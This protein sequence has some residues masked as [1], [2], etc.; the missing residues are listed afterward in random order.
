MAPGDNGRLDLDQLE[1]LTIMDLAAVGY[2]AGGEAA[3]DL[4]YLDDFA[5]LPKTVRQAPYRVG[6]GIGLGEFAVSGVGWSA[7]GGAVFDIVACDAGHP[8][9]A[10]LDGRGKPGFSGLQV[11]PRS[12]GIR[13]AWTSLRFDARADKRMAM[14]VFLDEDTGG[15]YTAIVQPNVTTEWQTFTV[16][17]TS[18]R[19][20][21]NKP[22]T[23]NGVLDTDRVNSVLLADVATTRGQAG[24]ANAFEIARPIVVPAPQ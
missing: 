15:A 10:R 18:F 1:Y 23:D 8:W 24:W 6:D 22:D 7:L 3:V 5:L 9:V 2:A 21:P 14:V 4:L 20:A 16:E 19:A 12:V 17:A 11:A 13:G